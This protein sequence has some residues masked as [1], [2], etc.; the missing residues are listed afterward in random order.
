MSGI[1]ILWERLSRSFSETVGNLTWA[2]ENGP[3]MVELAFVNGDSFH[4]HV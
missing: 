1:V 3:C 4:G 2:M